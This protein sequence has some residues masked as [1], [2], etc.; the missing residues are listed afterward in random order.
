M[1]EHEDAKDSEDR[2]I[3]KVCKMITPEASITVRSGEEVNIGLVKDNA[4]NT[5]KRGGGNMSQQHKNN[6]DKFLRLNQS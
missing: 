5:V 1:G 4:E 2:I 6:C 3:F